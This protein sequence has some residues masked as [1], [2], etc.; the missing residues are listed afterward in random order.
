MFRAVSADKMAGGPSRRGHRK[1]ALVAAMVF[2]LLP[3]PGRFAVA[4]TLEAEAESRGALAFAQELGN[5]AISRLTDPTLTDSM[6]V[7]RMRKLLASSFDLISI[8]RLVLGPY[9]TRAT[10]SQFSEFVNLYGIYV[11]HNYAGLFKRYSGETLKML[12][13]H[14]D[15]AGHITVHGIIR[16]T[17]GADSHLEMA[18]RPDNDSFKVLDIKVEG[19]S[20]PLAHQKQ[21]VSLIARKDGKV[22]SLIQALR[23]ADAR[24]E[25]DTPSE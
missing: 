17:D 15:A 8:S 22:S 16:Q 11:A 18:V 6:R 1:V 23:T 19:V 9:A 12:S 14:R 20:M 10:S 24:F 4:G 21:F 7:M 2:A 3:C 25:A 5:T 13:E